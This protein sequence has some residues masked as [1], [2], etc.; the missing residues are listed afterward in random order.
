MVRRKRPSWSQLFAFVLGMASIF[1]AWSETRY[2]TH[3]IE[4][5]LIDLMI[6]GGEASLSFLSV[7]TIFIAGLLLS[8][9]W[10]KA[11]LLQFSGLVLLTLVLV[12]TLGE[13]MGLE[14][15]LEIMAAALPKI[16]I[17]VYLAWTATLVSMPLL[18]PS[19]SRL[20][21]GRDR[22]SRYRSRRDRVKRV[23]DSS[24]IISPRA[25]ND[26]GAN[27]PRAP[28]AYD[29]AM[30][31]GSLDLG[32][33][34]LDSAL[35]AYGRALGVSRGSQERAAC[36]VKMAIVL[37]QMGCL[38]EAHLFLNEAKMLDPGSWTDGQG[39][40]QLLPMKKPTSK[41]RKRFGLS[42]E[43]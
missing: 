32:D 24:I 33:G 41:K 9:R 10:M 17:G 4:A 36:K 39:T 25:R 14:G 27:G 22:S 23:Q 26:A 5:R 6:E 3:Y 37:H 11:W 28:T 29:D 12:Q 38:E 21:H 7:G 1:L 2:G 35:R 16:G 43:P 30:A 19:F 20:T 31:R 15:M 13:T 40:A 18:R 8:L 34:N 42:P